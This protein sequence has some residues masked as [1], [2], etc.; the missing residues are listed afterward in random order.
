MPRTIA[1]LDYHLIKTLMASGLVYLCWWTVD[2]V[3][4]S[5][6]ISETTKK[7]NCLVATPGFHQEMV[8]TFD[9]IWAVRGVHYKHGDPPEYWLF[10]GQTVDMSQNWEPPKS[11]TI[12]TYFNV[13]YNHC[14]YHCSFFVPSKKGVCDPK[15]GDNCL[16]KTGIHWTKDYLHRLR[17]TCDHV[18]LVHCCDSMA[19]CGQALPPDPFLWLW[20]YQSDKQGPWWWFWVFSFANNGMSYGQS[21]HTMLN[22]QGSVHTRQLYRW[23]RKKN[24]GF[25]KQDWNRI[26]TA[27]YESSTQ[28]LWIIMSGCCNM[29]AQR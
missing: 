22:I 4:C 10:L 18:S 6:N 2:G 1:S 8:R 12:H 28:R 29:H 21:A 7:L 19:Q 14:D 25:Q 13:H 23:N 26:A 15:N 9:W 5:W 11:F 3:W 20:K 16:T 24:T 27:I 17:H